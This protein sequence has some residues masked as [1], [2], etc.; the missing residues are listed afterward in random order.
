MRCRLRGRTIAFFAVLWRS[1]LDDDDQRHLFIPS[2]GKSGCLPVGE[3]SF[4]YSNLVL[5]VRNCGG[6][7]VDRQRAYKRE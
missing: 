4:L 3:T 6:K 1:I 7:I 2:R 5:F